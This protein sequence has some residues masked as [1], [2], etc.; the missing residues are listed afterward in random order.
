MAKKQRARDTWCRHRTA[1][2]DKKHPVCA[3]GVDYHQF[4]QPSPHSPGVMAYIDMPCLGEKPEDCARCPKYSGWTQEEIDQRE[5]EV[6]ASI[7]RIGVAI[8]AIREHTK[9]QR[10]VQGDMTCPCCKLEMGLQ[11]SVASY[12]GHIRARCRTAG[13][14]SFMQ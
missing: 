13:C 4:R 6:E 2:D 7:A 8:S 14:V 11:F 1:F 9:R 3:V 10:G 5:I 12:N